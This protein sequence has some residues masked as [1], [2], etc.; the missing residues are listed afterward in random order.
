VKTKSSPKKTGIQRLKYY[1]PLFPRSNKKTYTRRTKHYQL[2]I[3]KRI[4]LSLKIR[5]F[6]TKSSLRSKKT[7]QYVIQTNR[8]GIREFALI[9]YIPSSKKSTPNHLAFNLSNAVIGIGIVGITFF[10]L[11][12]AGI[13]KSEPPVVNAQ[14][15]NQ[16]VTVKI[17]EPIEEQYLTASNP[18]RISIPSITVD[19]GVVPVGLLPNGEIETPDIFSNMVGSYKYAPTPGQKGPAVLIGHVDTY[20]GPSIFWNLSRLNISDTINI[21]REDGT[22]VNFAVE[23]VTQYSQDNFYTDEVYG[24]I[25]YAGLRII[26]C[27]GRYNYVTGR[28]SHNTVV[29][30]RLIQ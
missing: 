9:Y 3:T 8:F 26:T 1:K 11:Q 12:I 29:F 6:R 14:E 30:A 10:G 21:S 13:G 16:P 25:D 19:A 4:K 22:I 18:T 2:S 17:P 28:Y 15:N 20:K 24:N 23:K 7:K 27:G 5:T